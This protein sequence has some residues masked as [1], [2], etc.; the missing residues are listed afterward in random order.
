MTQRENFH[1]NIQHLV[2]FVVRRRRDFF[3]SCEHLSLVTIALIYIRIYRY[4]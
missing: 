4:N 3:K 1:Q 2:G